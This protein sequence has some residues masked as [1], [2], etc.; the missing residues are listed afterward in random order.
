MAKYMFLIF[1]FVSCSTENKLG[2]KKYPDAIGDIEYVK[3]IDGNFE[4]CGTYPSDPPTSFSNSYY[5]NGGLKYNGEMYAIKK[6]VLQNYKSPRILNQTG[7][8]TIRF[9]INCKG[10][11]GMFRLHS[12]DLELNEFKFEDQITT[13][14]LEIVQ[15]LNAWEILN[16]QDKSYDYYQYLTFKIVD[17]EIKEIAP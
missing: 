12:N 4:R 1:L 13:Q 14:L 9:L 6:Y 10:Q 2:L 3:S 15:N 7:L 8:L 5:G 16:Y 11:S 17:S